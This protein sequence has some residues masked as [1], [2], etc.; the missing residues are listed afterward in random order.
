MSDDL[1]AQVELTR[2]DIVA[3]L[4]EIRGLVAKLLEDKERKK[5]K[6]K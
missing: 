6:I 4:E 1:A 2:R 5:R 3:I